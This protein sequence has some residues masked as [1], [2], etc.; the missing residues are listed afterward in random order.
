[1]TDS[2]FICVIGV[3]VRA[4]FWCICAA[5]MPARELWCVCVY[6][7]FRI[8]VILCNI[9][10]VTWAKCEEAKKKQQKEID[11]YSV[12]WHIEKQQF[13]GHFKYKVKPIE[14]PKLILVIQEFLHQIHTKR[15]FVRISKSNVA[16]DKEK[17]RLRAVRKKHCIL[18]NYSLVSWCARARHVWFQLGLAIESLFWNYRYSF[19]SFAML[20]KSKMEK[21][22]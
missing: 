3:C 14:I 10:I 9:I 8:C 15:F 13:H 5:Q 17:K 6:K 4:R 7:V 2:D 21:N 11:M 18:E 19:S 12:H 20:T 16:I 22:S 1:M